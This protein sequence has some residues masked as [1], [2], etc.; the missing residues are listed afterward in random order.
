VDCSKCN[1]PQ[2]QHYITKDESTTG[3]FL[4]ICHAYQGNVQ[5]EPPPKRGAIEPDIKKN[6]SWALEL[7]RDYVDAT[8]FADQA[9]VTIIDRGEGDPEVIIDRGK[10]TSE[11]IIKE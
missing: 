10:K 2:R 5:T 11:V 7:E 4:C 8:G 6:A 3:C 1:H 9:P